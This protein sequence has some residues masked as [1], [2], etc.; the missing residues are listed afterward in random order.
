MRYR[1]R[2]QGR[3]VS[4]ESQPITSTLWPRDRYAVTAAHAE[5]L[6][7]LNS[8][9]TKY[10][11]RLV[12]E[13]SFVPTGG[14]HW[15][16]TVQLQI[17]Y[18]QNE[19]PPAQWIVPLGQFRLRRLADMSVTNTDGSRL[20]LLTRKQHG[21]ALSKAVLAKYLYSLPSGYLH[22][23]KEDKKARPDYLGLRH[24]LECYFT[25]VTPTDRDDLF[26]SI[27]SRYER[28]LVRAGMDND[29]AFAL[30]SDLADH[31]VKNRDATQYLC[32]VPARAGEVVNLQA[33]YTARDPEFEVKRDGVEATLAALADAM[34]RGK[35]DERQT[36]MKS[37]Y[38]AFGLAPINYEFRMPSPRGSG[39]YY[40]SLRPPM[41]SYVTYLDWETGNS[42]VESGLNCAYP[43]A[44]VHNSVADA[45][46]DAEDSTVAMRAYLRC[47]PHH[48]KQIV[49]TALLNIALVWLLTTEDFAINVSS[50]LAGILVASPSVVIAYLVRQQRHYYAHATRRQRAILWTYLGI[51]I[52]FLVTIAF[53]ISDDAL[54]SS[55]PVEVAAWMLALS[56][57]AIVGWYLPLGY[58]FDRVTR[59]LAGRKWDMVVRRTN[60]RSALERIDRVRRR[61]W[62]NRERFKA[63]SEEWQ[64]YEEAVAQYCR[65]T[66]G[67]AAMFVAVMAL[68]MA[69]MWSLPI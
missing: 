30:K 51:S 21:I 32:W 44:H 9:P 38:R 63:I 48:H 22:S 2:R 19:H 29:R 8:R 43:S 37:G 14:Q 61:V 64:C 11:Q 16:R 40:F 65:W 23:L 6:A 56:S 36:L 47:I 15:T 25:E 57:A 27:A 67:F 59:Y 52:G 39:S 60:Q 31:I 12:E 68:V 66:L 46:W 20:N 5:S 35:T 28:L 62:W 55:V 53:S 1:D 45:S 17:P 42:H 69:E 58:G 50:P 41:K 54:Q 7:E 18:G 34:R 24:D 49:G 13:L 3:Q 26:D 10:V 4:A 33:R